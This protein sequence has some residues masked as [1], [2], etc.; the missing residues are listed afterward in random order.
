MENDFKSPLCEG[1]QLPR[2]ILA[3]SVHSGPTLLPAGLLNE[4]LSPA[5]GKREWSH[6]KGTSEELS[7]PCEIAEN[8]YPHPLHLSLF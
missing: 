5:L 2:V 6:W 4:A 8:L 7:E 3:S 1:P